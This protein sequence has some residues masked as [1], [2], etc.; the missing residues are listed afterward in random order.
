MTSVLAH[1]AFFE[2]VK[3]VIAIYLFSYLLN[4]GYN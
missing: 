2:T 4:L 1:P 3:V